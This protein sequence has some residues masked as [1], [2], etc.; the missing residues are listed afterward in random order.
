MDEHT[1]KI[2]QIRLEEAF[3]EAKISEPISF[4]S[5]SPR[6]KKG[7][8]QNDSERPREDLLFIPRD[9]EEYREG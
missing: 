6:H 1:V 4:H 5:S 7:L 8:E 9:R 3:H 2:G